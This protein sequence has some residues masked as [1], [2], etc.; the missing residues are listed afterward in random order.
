M[1]E[2]LPVFYLFLQSIG[3]PKLNSQSS[4]MSS[5]IC[6]YH[7]SLP[8]PSFSGSNPEVHDVRDTEYPSRLKQLLQ[9]FAENRLSSQLQKM[10]RYHTKTDLLP[11]ECDCP[12]FWGT[13][14]FS[15]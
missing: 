7:S 3:Q 6:L 15:Q 11:C 8:P 2:N 13:V 5:C 10:H 12:F 14:H 1:P 4:P 9:P